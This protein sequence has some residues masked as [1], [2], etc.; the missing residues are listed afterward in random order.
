MIL[1]DMS[2]D[3]GK[4]YTN[5]SFEHPNEN[6]RVATSLFSKMF[7][8]TRKSHQFDHESVREITLD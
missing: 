4:F 3:T 7:L 8:P 2:S 5:Y 6:V 1:L